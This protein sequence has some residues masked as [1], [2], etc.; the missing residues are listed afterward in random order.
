MLSKNRS[1][2]QGLLKR[3]FCSVKNMMM[4]NLTK[5]LMYVVSTMIYKSLTEELIPK[6][7]KEVSMQVEVRKP[8]SVLQEQS[9]QMLTFSYSMIH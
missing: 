2:S 4:K 1:L 6:L 8:E 5:S 3:I 9:T 7:E